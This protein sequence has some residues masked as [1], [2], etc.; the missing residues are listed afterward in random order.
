[1]LEIYAGDNLGW[2]STYASDLWRGRFKV[3]YVD[4]PYNTGTDRR[5]YADDVELELWQTMLHD[6]FVFMR[7]CLA[8]DGVLFVS[9]GDDM[10]AHM[11]LLLQSVFGRGNYVITVIWDKVTALQATSAFVN[12][13][14]YICVVA[15]NAKR[16]GRLAL[17]AGE[18]PQYREV[19]GDDLFKAG[20]GR[21]YQLFRL[22][23]TNPRY[24][25]SDRLYAIETPVGSLIKPGPGR[26]WYMS[27]D[28]YEKMRAGDEIEWK[29]ASGQW[30]AY[31]KIYKAADG[32]R[33]PDSVLRLKVA[34]ERD[35][36][37]AL[38]PEVNDI[39][40]EHPKPVGLLKQL[41][42]MATYADKDAWVLDPYA[43]SG[44]TGHA[45]LSLNAADGGTR[46]GVLLQEE[47]SVLDVNLAREVCAERCVRARKALG[48]DDVI[49]YKAYDADC[50]TVVSGEL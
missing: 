38:F 25:G 22:D 28:G 11:R 4:P 2:L 50:L 14:E 42:Y 39:V 37:H 43:G 33:Q 6:R 40:F 9:I 20:S 31:R 34:G 48:S 49:M 8:E 30:V 12:R 19:D 27:R 1:M 5:E 13:H 41:V 36:L 3:I 23:R 16:M 35:T 44:T 47:G 17:P 7:D 15:K 26:C 45:I 24:K 18:Q 46:H 10:I 29:R 32:L 21:R